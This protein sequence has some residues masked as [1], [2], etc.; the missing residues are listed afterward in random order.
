MDMY[1]KLYHILFNSITDAIRL[2]D[3]TNPAASVL[4]NAQLECEEFF[5][6]NAPEEEN[7]RP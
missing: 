1:K 5:I 3:E 4:M 7:N 6:L 2:M